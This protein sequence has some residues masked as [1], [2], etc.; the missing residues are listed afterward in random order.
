MK[1]EWRKTEKGYYLPGTRP[2]IVHIPAFRFFTLAGAG[3]PNDPFFGKYIEALYTLAY[4]VKMSARSGSAPQDFYDYSVYPLEGIWDLNESAKIKP[5]GPM[6]KDDLIFTLMIRQPD[7]VSAAF[8]SQIVERTI[9]KK[10]NELLAKVKF[11]TIEEG[12]C[13]QMMHMGSFDL[14]VESFSQMEM[15]CQTWGLIRTGHQ[16]REIYLSDARKTS[17]DKLKTVLRFRIRK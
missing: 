14:E 10:S 8:A 15:F 3:N 12:D 4:A 5:T 7:F 2:E 1:Q 13:V 9:K 16:H 6:N 11:E 17:Q